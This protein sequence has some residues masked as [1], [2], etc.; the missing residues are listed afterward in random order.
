MS[1]LRS[2]SK[3]AKGHVNLWSPVKLLLEMRN[4]WRCKVHR[5]RLHFSE[6]DAIS[7]F[8]TH[9]T[10]AKCESGHFKAVSLKST[11]LNEHTTGVTLAP[12]PETDRSPDLLI[13]V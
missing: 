12:A 3:T 1:L 5:N 9:S 7:L 8:Y 11:F 4:N 6:T 10:D 2:Q 13:M